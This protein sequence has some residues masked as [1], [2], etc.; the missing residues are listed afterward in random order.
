MGGY[1]IM[2]WR[3]G[4]LLFAVCWMVQIV[5][6]FLQMRHYQK[7]LAGLTTQWAD[8]FV[9]SGSARSS[10]GR[11]AITILVVAPCG[12]VR[13]ALV[14]QGRTT[15]AKFKPFPSLVGQD[16]EAIRRGT[17]FQPRDA[18]LADAF[19]AAVDQVEKII[20]SRGI[21]IA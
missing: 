18:R 17:P 5:G 8:G 1:T 2:D 7:I 6:T 15:W 13:Q 20:A 9:G 12:T 11:G 3:Y 21:A 16:L 19:R 10:F 4:L 14:M